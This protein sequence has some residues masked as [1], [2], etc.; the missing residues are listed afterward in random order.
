MNINDNWLSVLST[1]FIKDQQDYADLNIYA[2]ADAAQDKYFLKSL[3]HLRQKCLLTEAAG[4]KAREV[5]PHLL[6][7]P[8]DFSAS[9]W[10]W[11]EKHIAGT[12]KMTILTS[13]L[14]FELLYEHLRQFLEVK[15][16]GGLEMILAFWD[17]A[18]LACLVGHKEDATLYISDPVLDAAQKETLLRPV[19][20]WWYWDRQGNL[21]VIT[22]TNEN[23][24]LLPAFHSSLFFTV[25]QEELMIEATF[26]D[27]LSYYLRLN[28]GFLVDKFT[29]QE[30]YDLIINSLPA[31]R[32]YGLTGTRDI[33]NFMCLQL[34]YKENF[35]TNPQLQHALAQV[36]DK[37]LSMDDAMLQLSNQ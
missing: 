31:A 22:G 2:I 28:N 35:D 18:I 33:L 10:T 27:N 20:R 36:K 8:V 16:E 15:F 14:P 23:L 6:Q 9:E 29:D 17:P 32:S 11:I 25:E 37:I 19:K 5:S 12:P 7:L 1:T 34:I 26:P 21:Q 13:S 24:S 30:L 3:V 4:D